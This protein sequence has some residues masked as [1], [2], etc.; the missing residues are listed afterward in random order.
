M[1]SRTKRWIAGAISAAMLTGILA[2]CASQAPKE[3]TVIKILYSNNFEHVEE[4]VESTYEDIDLQV[5][6]SPYPSEEIRRLEKGEGPDLVIAAHPDSNQVQKY[7][8]DLSDTKTSLV[9][10]GTIMNALKLEGKTYLI[11]FPGVY[12][13]YIINETLFEEAGLTLP[14]T[15]DELVASLA[16]LK[17]KGLGLGED[18]INFSIF[19]D[20][21]SSVGMF[22]VGC[23][24]PDFLGE[25]EGVQWL[26]DFRDKKAAFAG[27][28]EKSFALTDAL[29]AGGLMDPAAIARQRNLVLCQRRLGNG[30]LAAAFGDSAMYYE[31]VAENKK[32]VEE[33]ISREYSYRMLPL[34][35]DE[36]N[37]PWFLFAPS[38]LMGINN[39][40]SEEKQDACK[41]IL[42]IL[43][44]TEGQ[45]ALNQDLGTGIS[46]LLDYEQAEGGIPAGV[47][48]YVESGYIYNVLFPS[49]TVEYLGGC[50]RDVLAGK[51][52][53]EEAL[54]A[55]DESYYEGTAESGYDFTV[56]GEMEHELPMENF[57]V[58]R[59]ETEIGNF[60]ADCV[61]EASNAQIAVV[62]GGGIRASFYEGVVY[63][64]DLSAVCPFDN[65][66][67]V[68]EMNGQTMWDMLENGLAVCTDE[69]PGGRFLQISGLQYTFDSS[70]P[71][72]SRL[73]SVEMPDGTSLDL[74]GDYQVAVTDYMAGAAG[75]AEDNGDGYTMLNYYDDAV[76]KGSV[77]L[78]KDTGLTY[79]DAMALYFE[80]H[81][82]SAVDA[83]IEGR[84][85]DLA[86]DK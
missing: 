83:G 58:R 67:I 41:R 23:M 15:N 38:A 85:C 2:G 46:C 72:G 30:T 14:S 53:V 42:S 44:T 36:G 57:N 59:R 84:I 39:A 78:V 73:V 18:G 1:C 24:V 86:Q 66:I 64:G 71:A 81:S 26:S 35:S 82:D 28:W 29:V 7:L 45:D 21:N 47:E 9:Y 6:I 49:K 37:E 16:E 19:S 13:G 60:I 74:D 5:E 61:L 25:M 51:K 54:Q 3:K 27:V 8:L 77:T 40:I 43:S 32:A 48:G 50:V 55:V 52:S 65:K 75:Y 68:L 80:Q 70:K 56:I 10:D 33:G 31:C 62:N 69:F 4:L 76:P 22:F 20:Y 11:P 12:S 79:R 63:G 17:E 34:F